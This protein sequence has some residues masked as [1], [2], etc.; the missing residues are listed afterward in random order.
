MVPSLPTFSWQL[1][2]ILTLPASDEELKTMSPP[3]NLT[4]L[5]P[6]TTF[7]PFFFKTKE[8]ATYDVAAVLLKMSSTRSPLRTRIPVH[9]PRFTKCS[10]KPSMLSAIVLLPPGRK[11]HCWVKVWSVA[12]AGIRSRGHLQLLQKPTKLVIRIQVGLTLP[13]MSTPEDIRTSLIEQVGLMTLHAVSVI[14]TLL[15]NRLHL[16]SNAMGT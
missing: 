14:H 3:E 8:I 4:I 16:A 12:C 2:S 1:W 7:G 11:W 5:V 10:R 9:G 15:P 6:S 13:E